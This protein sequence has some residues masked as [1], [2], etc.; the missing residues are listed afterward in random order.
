MGG[1]TRVDDA[2]VPQRVGVGPSARSQQDHRSAEPGFRGAVSGAVRPSG[3]HRA[4]GRRHPEPRRT[5]A[6]GRRGTPAPHRAGLARAAP[7][8]RLVTPPPWHRYLW[9]CERVESILLGLFVAPGAVV[10][11]VGVYQSS[12]DG[13]GDWS[14]LDVTNGRDERPDTAVTGLAEN[15]CRG[16]ERQDAHGEHHCEHD[17]RGSH[18][19][20]AEVCNPDLRSETDERQ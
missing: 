20:L 4:G 18:T 12:R 11:V 10:P 8:G 15:N 3:D 9:D 1:G 16:C 13:R 19:R 7:R 6:A 14:P 17:E 2:C 5:G